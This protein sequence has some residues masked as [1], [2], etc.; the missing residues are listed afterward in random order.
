MEHPDLHVLIQREIH[1]D[2]D[3]M[4]SQ[5]RR[6]PKPEG[7]NRARRFTG[8]ALIAIGARIAPTAERGAT[9]PITGPMPALRPDI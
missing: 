8:N 6:L 9:G 1:N 4:A 3:R 2:R 5:Q 7:F